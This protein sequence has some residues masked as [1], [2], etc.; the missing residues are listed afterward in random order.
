MRVM[1]WQMAQRMDWAPGGSCSGVWQFEQFTSINMMMEMGIGEAQKKLMEFDTHRER[2]RERGRQRDTDMG[3]EGENELVMKSLKS[4][5]AW[6]R[7]C[8]GLCKESDR[9]LSQGQFIG[10]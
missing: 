5:R 4:S 9:Q 7:A 1:A 3:R 10:L 6:K 2:E 8:K